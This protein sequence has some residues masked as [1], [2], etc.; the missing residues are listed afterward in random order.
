[1]LKLPEKCFQL[2]LFRMKALH[3]IFLG[4]ELC[5]QQEGTG[6]CWESRMGMVGKDKTLVYLLWDMQ[7]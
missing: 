2:L 1:M 5:T 4:L 6:E 7:C 3:G